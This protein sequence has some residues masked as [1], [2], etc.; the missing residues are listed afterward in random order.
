MH[1]RTSYP[2]YDFTENAEK[3]AR[4]GIHKSDN[5]RL[6]AEIVDY[7]GPPEKP[8]LPSG[9]MGREV[10]N[11]EFSEPMAIQVIVQI[12]IHEGEEDADIW[13]AKEK[14]GEWVWIRL[15]TSFVYDR[16]GKYL[17]ARLMASDPPIAVG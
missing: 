1:I 5:Q 4:V 7:K 2:K 14:N 10:A 8:I 6:S 9:E 3:G 16:N 11:V 15:V 13:I 12:S 17:E